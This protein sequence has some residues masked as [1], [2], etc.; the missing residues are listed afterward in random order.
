MIL[1]QISCPAVIS[2]VILIGVFLA[3]F[4]MS[5]FSGLLIFF[6]AVSGNWVKFF[7]SFCRRRLVQRDLTVT[8]CV[9]VLINSNTW[10]VKPM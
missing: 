10:P 8:Y 6:M 2:F 4:F 3:I 7:F 5:K 9:L 1:K